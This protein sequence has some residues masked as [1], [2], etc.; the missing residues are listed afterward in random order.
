MNK[1]K[2]YLI[3]NALFFTFYTE[4]VAQI[5]INSASTPADTKAML[6]IKSTDKGIFIP[7]L[8]TAQRTGITGLTL[9]EHQ[10]LLVYDTDFNALWQF[11]GTAW[12]Q[13]GSTV[14]SVWTP[15]NATTIYTDKQ[16]VGI[17]NNDPKA[18]LH[19]NGQM[20]I[21]TDGTAPSTRAQL[22]VKSTTKGLHTPRMTTV[23][24]L[25][26]APT[27][28]D[29]G[30]VVF[31]LNKNRFYMFDGQN[32][33]PFAL[34]STEESALTKRTA[35]DGVLDETFG[36][37]VSISGDYAIIG[38]QSAVSLTGAAYIF[39]RSGNIWTQQA[40]LA[41]LDGTSNDFFG[42]NVAISGDYAVVSAEAGNSFRGAAY[43]FK[44][45]GTNWNQQQK[46]IASDVEPYDTFGRSVAISGDYVIVGSDWYSALGN[47][48]NQGS[49]YIY[50]FNGTTWGEESKIVPTDAVVQGFFGHSVAISGNYAI[51][52]DRRKT[53][54]GKAFQGAAYIFFRN[55]ATN[56]WAQ[57]AKLTALDGAA[58]DI[59]GV[60]VG[61]SGD[62]AIVGASLAD[63]TSLDQGA[64][65]IFDRT[66]TTW[67]QR[68]KL[69]ASDVGSLDGFGSSVAISG[70]Y[71]MVGVANDDIGD[72]PNQGSVYI[73][74]RNGHGWNPKWHILNSSTTSAAPQF[75]RAVSITPSACIVGEPNGINSATGV[76]MGAVHFSV[77]DF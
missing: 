76:K 73:F 6:D 57:Q 13:I 46:L 28:S 2:K 32:W 7:R 51:V 1:I 22:A 16:Q 52:A 41:P 65:Y 18:A 17:N 9:L 19:V 75:G 45:T 21:N 27:G 42:W 44:R 77:I 50:H 48:N 63:G 60:S 26:I 34:S 24:R 11:N 23:E 25:A 68:L 30:L 14:A 54:S 3:I 8:T 15:T 49:A 72:T 20:A 69:I 29:V 5:A 53:V 37:S 31:D 59:F 4:G 74:K 12:A 47:T 62:Y 39:F 40:K 38:A 55:P 71:A 64:A 66:G 33:L 36:T 61:I 58:D 70:D 67:E 56:T 35:S 10:G 43:I